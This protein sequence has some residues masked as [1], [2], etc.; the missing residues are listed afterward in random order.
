MQ[1]KDIHGLEST[2]SMLRSAVANNH[3]AHAQLFA[4]RPGAPALPM[5]LAFATYLNCENPTDTDSC[6]QC[7]QCTKNKKFIHPDVHFVFPVSATKSIAAKDLESRKFLKEWRQFLLTSPYGN[8]NDWSDLYSGEGKQAYISTREKLN[9]IQDLSLKAFEGTYKIMLIWY[10]ELM[11][12]NAANGILKV[13]EEPPEN[14]LFLLVSEQPD[15]LLTTI[16]SRVQRLNIPL[17][18]SA[19]VSEQLVLTHGV[20]E[21]RAKQIAHLAEGSLREA[22][23]LAANVD[24]N[25]FDNFSNWM[26]QCFKRDWGLLIDGADNFAKLNRAKQ[27]LY[28]QYGL[29]LVREALVAAQPETGMLVRVDGKEKPFVANLGKTLN[30]IQFQHLSS[31]FSDASYHL[32]RNANPKLL[33]MNLSIHISKTFSLN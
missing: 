30:T 10:P 18:T 29:S 17:F 5:A 16:T 7:S 6:G 1:F 27:Q 24:S 26:R 13:L 9:I 14:T 21:Q 33:F 32:E 31:L 12:R 20:N 15:L 22:L 28:L 11:H 3:V 4:G 23:Y 2:K 8:L 19:E 25:H